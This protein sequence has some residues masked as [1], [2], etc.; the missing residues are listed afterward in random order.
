MHN[1]AAGIISDSSHVSDRITLPLRGTDF[2]FC[3]C[4]SRSAFFAEDFAFSFLFFPI[5]ITF[6][7]CFLFLVAISR[8]YST[9]FFALIVTV[10]FCGVE[11]VM[12]RVNLLGLTGTAPRICSAFQCW[13]KP[14]SISK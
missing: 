10:D 12:A 5:V 3:F 9:K 1:T 2:F 7:L 14:P 13:K 11:A 8:F 4:C 6:H